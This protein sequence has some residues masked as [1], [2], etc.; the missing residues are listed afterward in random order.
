M[1]LLNKTNSLNGLVENLKN[2]R[3]WVYEINN[4]SLLISKLED[5]KKVTSVREIAKLI[6]KS[7]SWVG[8][9]LILVTGLKIYPEISKCRS[10]NQ[11]Y[12]YLQK[13]NKLRRFLES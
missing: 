11:A 1:D 3:D 9:S 10:R 4:L 2:Q 12:H 6:N 5:L 8:V 13:K 7:K